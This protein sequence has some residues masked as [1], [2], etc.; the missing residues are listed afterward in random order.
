MQMIRTAQQE[1]AED[2]FFGQVVIIWARWFLILAGTILV[3]WNATESTDL[4]VAILPIIAL[5]IMNFYTHG[6][7]LM[8]KPIN[9]NLLMLTCL[10]DVVVITLIVLLWKPVGMQSEF[11]VFYYP[12]V[13][14]VAF[15]FPQQIT[16]VYTA[17][18]LLTYTIVSFVVSSPMLADVG[19]QKTLIQRLI[20]IGAMG[21][22]GAFYWRIQRNR[23]RAL[24]DK[25][26]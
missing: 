9:T 7:Y 22:L 13:L 14:G 8:E 6:R 17:L 2:I 4:V 12:I 24:D 21:G 25:K 15:V 1:A 5:M 10:I 19:Y 20:T 23:R 16:A 26:K 18:V 3:L 11:F